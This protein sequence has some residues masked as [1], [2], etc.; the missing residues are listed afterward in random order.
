L[1]E[2]GLHCGLMHVSI[3]SWVCGSGAGPISRITIDC[4][5]V[6]V[7]PFLQCCDHWPQLSEFNRSS[8]SL[9]T[10]ICFLVIVKSFPSVSA[11]VYISFPTFA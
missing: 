8:H 6:A 1:V 7:E 2:S 3:G 5:K 9:A 10:P 11:S 4:R